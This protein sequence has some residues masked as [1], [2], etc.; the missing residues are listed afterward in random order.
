MRAKRPEFIAYLREKGKTDLRIGNKS[1]FEL[2]QQRD[3]DY[4]AQFLADQATAAQN[5]L[6]SRVIDRNKHKSG[7]LIYSRPSPLQTYLTTKHQPGR[8]LM[9]AIRYVRTPKRRDT[10]SALQASCLSSLNDM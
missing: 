10:S 3:T 6:E 7:V 5:N 1:L 4:H 8:V 2:A 9:D